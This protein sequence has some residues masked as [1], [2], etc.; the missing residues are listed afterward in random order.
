MHRGKKMNG[1]K[2]KQNVSTSFIS[3]GRQVTF[4]PLF[5]A[6]NTTFRRK[7]KWQFKKIKMNKRLNTIWEI[8]NH[9][10]FKK[11]GFQRIYQ[12]VL[13]SQPNSFNKQCFKLQLLIALA[14]LNTNSCR[15]HINCYMPI[16]IH[17]P[18]LKLTFAT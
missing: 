8:P 11:S 13:L 17:S 14:L 1:N 7:K 9:P 15:A 18:V 5:F 10:A 6:I 16:K 12:V 3:D 2:P 4:L